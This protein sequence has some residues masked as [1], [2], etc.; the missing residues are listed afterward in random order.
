MSTPWLRPLTALFPKGVVTS[1]AETLAAHAGDALFASTLP[2][3]VIFP[4]KAEDVAALLRF[5]N[6]RKIPV[7]ARGA[8]RGYVGGCVPKKS[9]IVVSFVK[10]NR[11][12]ELNPVDG[13]A[14]V[15][16]GVITGQFQAQARKLGLLYPPDPAS[17]K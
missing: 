11:V 6:R 17:L 12:L 7:T 16:P 1:D 15:Q 5:A 14:I 4:R 10:M 13:V 2:Q 8:G 9:G 3:A